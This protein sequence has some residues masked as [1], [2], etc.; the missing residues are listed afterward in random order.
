MPQR[1]YEQMLKMT[2][3]NPAALERLE[4]V[5]RIVNDKDYAQDFNVLYAQFKPLIPKLKQLL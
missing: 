3:K 2:V 4:D 1:I 5:A